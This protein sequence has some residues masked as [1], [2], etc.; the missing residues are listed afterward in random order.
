MWNSK[1]LLSR[2]QRVRADGL[3]ALASTKASAAEPTKINPS[4]LTTKRRGDQAEALALAFLNRAGLKLIQSNYKTPGRGGGEIDLV[5]QERDS[6]LVFIEVRQRSTQSHGGAGASI[7]THKQR[8]IILAARYFLMQFS[9]PPPCRF[10]VLLMDGKLSQA[11]TE[12]IKGAF[13]AS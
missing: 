5:M 12:W 3:P 1:K 8:R 4:Q 6:T 7:S 13:E 2:P 9:S 11:N 10:D